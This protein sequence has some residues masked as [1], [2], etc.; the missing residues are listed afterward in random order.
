LGAAAM[1]WKRS[2]WRNTAAVSVFNISDRSIM[3]IAARMLT[4]ASD[5]IAG[6]DGDG[7]GIVSGGAELR[8][9]PFAL[10]GRPCAADT[11]AQIPSLHGT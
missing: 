1:L 7:A 3:I 10:G 8:D 4:L 11:S 2:A 5:G 9:E 6:L